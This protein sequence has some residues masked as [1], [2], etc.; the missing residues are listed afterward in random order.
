VTFLHAF[1]ITMVA[2]LAL[3]WR[4]KHAPL[5]MSKQTFCWR[6]VIARAMALVPKARMVR[7]VEKRILRL[8]IYRA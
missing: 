8:W 6:G 4:P 1:V 7:T 2:L 3:A 5:F